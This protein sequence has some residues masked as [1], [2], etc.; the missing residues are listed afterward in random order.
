MIVF[1]FRIPIE[2]KRWMVK[3]A[4]HRKVT[5]QALAGTMLKQAQQS[6]ISFSELPAAASHQLPDRHDADRRRSK[7]GRRG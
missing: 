4:H 7:R 5:V 6:L 3:E 1:G 2:L